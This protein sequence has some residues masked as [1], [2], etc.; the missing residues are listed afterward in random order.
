MPMPSSASTGITSFSRSRHHMEY[1]LCTAATGRTA[2]ALRMVPAAA[3]DMPKFSTFPAWMRLLNGSGDVFDGDG[4]VDPVLV[5]QVD[6]VGAQPA[7]G[8]VDRPPDAVG[9]AGHSAALDAILGEREAELGGDFDLV[10]DGFEG[11]ADDLFIGERAVHLGGVEEGDALVHG[12]PD[13]GD[14]V[15]TRR[16]AGVAVRAGEAHAA[17]AN[18]RHGQAVASEGAL[19]H[20]RFLSLLVGD[21]KSTRLNSS[22]TVISYAVFCLKKKKKK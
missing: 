7:Q 6:V 15:L 14:R 9:V 3:S 8:V 12:V 5:V 16:A 18:L 22:H 21:R 1:S 2:C 13:Q 11:F 20:G 4:G 10:P 19:L 17:Q